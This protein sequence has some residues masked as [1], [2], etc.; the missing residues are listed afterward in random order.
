VS[1]LFDDAMRLI[2]SIARRARMADFPPFSIGATM[3][4]A[5]FY[6]IAPNG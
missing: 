6:E 2:E 5:E 3:Q 4:A 1:I